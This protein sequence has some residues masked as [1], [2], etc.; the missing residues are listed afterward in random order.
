MGTIKHLILFLL[1]SIGLSY[2]IDYNI[3]NSDILFIDN[4]FIFENS[5]ATIKY[6]DSVFDIY[7]LEFISNGSKNI[8]YKIKDIRWVKSN[9]QIHDFK[10]P[11][12][13][14]K[15]DNFLYK[16]CPMIYLDIFPYKLDENNNLYYIEYLDIEFIGENIEIN[17][18]CD[19][20]ENIINKNF[21]FINDLKLYNSATIK[22]INYSSVH[23][24]LL[25]Y[26]I[27]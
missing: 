7:R 12:L 24:I 27:S 8:Q 16:G 5:N 20:K 4:H 11:D 26:T 9:H 19:I 14:S 10:M 18:F 17:G 6:Q 21:I 2:S 3:Q 22:L 13:I 23:S 1:L 25:I 15:S